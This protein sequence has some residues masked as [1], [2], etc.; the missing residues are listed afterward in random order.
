MS[1]KQ[2][3]SPG[4]AKFASKTTKGK[5]DEARKG[6]RMGRGIPFAIGTSGEGNVGNIICDETKADDDGI[7]HPRIRVE[8]IISSPESAKG[9]VISGPGLMQTIKDGKDPEKWSKEMAWGAALGLL[10]SL[11]CPKELTEGYDEFQEVLDWFREEPRPVAWEVVDSSWYNKTTKK[12]VEQKG[13]SAVAI[14]DESNASSAVEGEKMEEDP[15][16]V[17]CAYRGI[18][19]IILDED[20]DVATIKNCNTGR[21]R[22]NVPMD[23]IEKE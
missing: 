19:H 9:K 4:F 7:S 6:E 5:F 10:E 18:R 3:V 2:Q 21:V 16:G 22:E 14:L 12:T 8:I 1:D 13:I 15:N 17:Y 23:Q 20:D 11:G